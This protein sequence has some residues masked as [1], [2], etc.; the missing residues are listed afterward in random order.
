[1]ALKD[2]ILKFS[3][4]QIDDAGNVLID[5]NSS[6]Q[7]KEHALEILLIPSNQHSGRN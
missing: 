1:M 7:E 5:S 3:E 2:N 6:I 4:R